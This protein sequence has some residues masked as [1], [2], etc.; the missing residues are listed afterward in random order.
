MSNDEV[1]DVKSDNGKGRPTGRN[2]FD[3]KQ[4]KLALQNVR[5]EA[6]EKRRLDPKVEPIPR[7]AF[8]DV[9]KFMKAVNKAYI[10]AFG[11]VVHFPEMMPLNNAD[12][13]LEWRD[14]QKIFTLSIGGDGHVV[15]AGVFGPQSKIRGVFTFT[16][17]HMLSIIGMIESV[18]S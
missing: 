16:R 14:G 7:S 17:P 4:V 13:G 10:R 6:D 11:H 12:I 5:E 8:K 15:F 3:P 18:Y 1:V 9:E 2:N